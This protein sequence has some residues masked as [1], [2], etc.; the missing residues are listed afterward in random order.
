MINYGTFPVDITNSYCTIVK[1]LKEKNEEIESYEKV[2]VKAFEKFKKCRSEASQ[3]SMKKARNLTIEVCIGV[4][5]LTIGSE[6]M[7]KNRKGNL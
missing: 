5:R 2:A 1:K 4:Y 3:N 6:R 7:K